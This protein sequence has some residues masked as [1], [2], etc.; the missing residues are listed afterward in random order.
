MEQFEK[1]FPIIY[2]SQY[3]CGVCKISCDFSPLLP[4]KYHVRML[5]HKLYCYNVIWS[6]SCMQM[7]VMWV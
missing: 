2:Y 3:V 7:Y 5:L 1:L 4:I 6:V